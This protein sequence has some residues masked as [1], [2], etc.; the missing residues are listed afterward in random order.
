MVSAVA[1]VA[2][3]IPSVQQLAATATI[4]NK[5][6]I[7]KPAAPRLRLQR[8]LTASTCVV[9][10]AVEQSPSARQRVATVTVQRVSITTRV[11]PPRRPLQR[12]V[13]ASM[14]VAA[15]V[16]DQCHFAHQA[17][18]LV[19]ARKGKITTRAALRQRRPHALVLT[20]RLD[21]ILHIRLVALGS[22]ARWACHLIIGRL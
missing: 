5:R 17:A 15:V 22:G 20:A 3:C 7:T 1:N 13:A 18:A 12:K 6:I 21:G 19:T 8:K 4:Q 11:A 16:A 9:P 10:N 14:S 2:L